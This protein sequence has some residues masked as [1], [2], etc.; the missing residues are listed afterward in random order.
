MRYQMFELAAYTI[1][2]EFGYGVYTP[3][4]PLR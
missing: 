4:S 3:Y 1:L 2:T